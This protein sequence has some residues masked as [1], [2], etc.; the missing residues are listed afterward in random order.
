MDFTQTHFALFGL[1]ATYALD[2]EHL[3][4]AYREMQNTVHPD[5]FAAQSDA[6]QRVAMQWATRANEAYRTLKHPVDRGVYLLQLQGID[7]LDAHNT[8]MAPAF[9][10]QQM[11]W[12]EAI[13]DA[14]GAKRVDALD[15]LMDEL[16]ITHRQIESQLIDL[17]DAKQDFE[18]AREAVRQ[19]RFM[20]KLIA[21][22]GD[23]YE[24]L[25]G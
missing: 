2:R 3:D 17:L 21:E 15:A 9:L 25:E 23:V 5:R 4:R 19:L 8:Q 12:R 7:A 16:R 18:G 24:E 1:P 6:E 11:E 10:M 14:R 20:D 13:D 22:V